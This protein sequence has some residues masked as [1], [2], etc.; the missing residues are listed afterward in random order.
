M[1][2]TQLDRVF[3]GFDEEHQLDILRKVVEIY[4]LIQSY[5]LPE[6]VRGYGGLGF[7]ES[8]IIVTG[9]TTTPCSGPSSQFEDKT[10]I[11]MDYET[12]SQVRK[13]SHPPQSLVHG[14]LNMYN[15]L[16]NPKSHCITAILVLDFAAVAAAADE[17]FYSPVRL[18]NLTKV[19]F[20]SVC[21]R[22]S[23][24]TMC[25]M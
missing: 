16:Y 25:L 21:W 6:T 18:K 15:M 19:G 13:T 3:D 7:D 12:A 5:T 8:G 10:G 22:G 4:K 23:T 14:D 17:Y 9:P 11:E 20:K 1:P 2:G 24:M